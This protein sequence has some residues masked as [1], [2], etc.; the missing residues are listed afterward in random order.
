[1]PPNAFKRHSHRQKKTGAKTNKSHLHLLNL[2]IFSNLDFN[3]PPH[4]RD[5]SILIIDVVQR[6]NV[7]L[8]HI[9]V[10]INVA[11]ERLYVIVV[12]DV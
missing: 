6:F 8:C 4:Y 10:E 7:L 1:M 2:L 5:L 11:V 12:L 3:T 9:H